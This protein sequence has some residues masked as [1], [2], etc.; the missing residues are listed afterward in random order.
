MRLQPGN[1]KQTHQKNV[2]I[3]SVNIQAFSH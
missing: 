2:K 3:A 1:L